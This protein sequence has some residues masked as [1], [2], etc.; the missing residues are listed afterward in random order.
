MSATRAWAACMIAGAIGFVAVVGPL[1]LLQ[2][3]YDPRYQ[4]MSELALGP[5]GEWM[6]LA[7]LSMALALVGAGCLAR[8][9]GAPVPVV[10]LFLA[11][12]AGFVAAGVFPLGA[13]TDLHVASIALAFVLSVL[14]IYLAPSTAG[15]MAGLAPRWLSWTLAAGVALAVVLGHSLLPMGIGQRLAAACLLAWLVTV[16]VRGVKA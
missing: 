6:L 5:H 1:H 8:A 14:A 11:A 3:G 15:R 16:G 7:F 4:L 9:V 13:T 10:L 2:P 12:S